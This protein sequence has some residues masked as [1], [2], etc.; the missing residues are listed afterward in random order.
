MYHIHTI[1]QK[2]GTTR[3]AFCKRYTPVTRD[4]RNKFQ[5]LNYHRKTLFNKKIKELQKKKKASIS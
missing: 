3:K 4:R 2:T 1:L 5:V